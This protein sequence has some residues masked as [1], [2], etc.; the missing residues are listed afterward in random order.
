MEEADSGQPPEPGKRKAAATATLNISK[1]SGTRMKRVSS[2]LR[3]KHESLTAEDKRV[4]E[5]NAELVEQFYKRK[6]KRAVWLS[7][8]TELEDSAEELEEKCKQMAQA[9]HDAE[10]LVVYTGAGIST[11]ASIPDYRGPNGI[12]TL[13]QK[14]QDIGHHDL[15]AAE[16]TLTHMALSAL[17]HQGIVKH[18]VSQNCDGLH[19]RSGLPKSAM[20]EVHGNMYIEV[21]KNCVPARE[22]VRTF[23]VTERTSTFKHTTGRRCYRCG[24]PVIDTIVHFGERGKL[25]WPLNWQGACQAANACDTILCLGSSLKVLK[26]YPWLWQMDRPP[27]KRPSLY[28]VNLQWTPKDKD[29]TLKI[30]GKC[31][32]VMA[33]VMKAMGYELPYYCRANDPI[34]Y[35]ATPLHEAEV[36]ISTRPQLVPPS[37][38]DEEPDVENVTDDKSKECTGTSQASEGDVRWKDSDGNIV[39]ENKRRKVED[40]EEKFSENKDLLI[41]S[42]SESPED[43]KTE[44]KT[45]IKNE[46]DC[47][48]SE[49]KDDVS[50]VNGIC[51]ALDL[52]NYNFCKREDATDGSALNMKSEEPIKTEQQLNDVEFENHGN[53]GD[54]WTCGFG[55]LYKALMS[56]SIDL[57][58]P[59]STTFRESMLAEEVK[60]EASENEV[61]AMSLEESLEDDDVKSEASDRGAAIE[62]FEDS[63]EDDEGKS[64]PLEEAMADSSMGLGGSYVDSV[65]DDAK[66]EFSESDEE[67]QTSEGD[68]VW[69][70]DEASG[71][72]VSPRLDPV[73]TS[74]SSSDSDVS[75]K[76]DDDYE[77]AENINTNVSSDSSTTNYFKLAYAS[78]NIQMAQQGRALLQQNEF[79][80]TG[81]CI[82]S[83]GSSKNK[84][85]YVGQ[86][87]SDAER[88][89]SVETLSEGQQPLDLSL[90]VNC[91]S[92]D[93]NPKNLDRINCNDLSDVRSTI[94]QEMCAVDKEKISSLP[95]CHRSLSNPVPS[96]N[97]AGIKGDSLYGGVPVGTC[98]GGTKLVDFYNSFVSERLR[99]VCTNLTKQ[100]SLQVLENKSLGRNGFQDMDNSLLVRTHIVDGII[101]TAYAE[102]ADDKDSDPSAKSGVPLTKVKFPRSEFFQRNEL[103]ES[104][105]L[106][107]LWYQSFCNTNVGKNSNSL[108]S[109]VKNGKVVRQKKENGLD[110][111][112]S[113]SDLNPS[114][115][116][117]S[118][119]ILKDICAEAMNDSVARQKGSTKRKLKGCDNEDVKYIWFWGFNSNTE[120]SN[121]T[122]EKKCITLSD[123]SSNSNS[124]NMRASEGSDGADSPPVARV[125]RSRTRA[126]SDSK[127]IVE[128]EVFRCHCS[129]T[130]PELCKVARE[131]P[132]REKCEDVEKARELFRRRRLYNYR[133]YEPVF[134][135]EL[136]SF[137][138]ERSKA[139]RKS[140]F[141]LMQEQDED[142]EE[143]EEEEQDTEPKEEEQKMSDVEEVKEKDEK[144][145]KKFAPGWYGKGLR[146]GMKKKTRI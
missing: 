122:P 61:N 133:K 127:V 73:K 130:N 62:S 109:K 55:Q 69:L 21:C 108:P 3:K 11:A 102:S 103:S 96:D 77:G 75:E 34:F 26:K 59:Y 67:P 32:V 124:E 104:E 25:R 78:T 74:D 107:D 146:K 111:N 12:W 20:S 80:G 7:R 81:L 125:T 131:R 101:Q 79:Y 13:L 19:L 30:N 43:I 17:Y 85:N 63:L 95:S 129:G 46:L 140:K 6:E 64:Q 83:L 89:S 70:S 56:K 92:F 93:A 100:E 48:K 91:K 42:E 142:G 16:P 141:E 128:P 76:S 113:R 44:V 39:E 1:K 60:S 36:N 120:N 123:N 68:D 51:T 29:A 8:K 82:R 15:S 24:E 47:V 66:S 90:P 137:T 27:K 116:K 98:S 23:D 136:E 110:F 144:E 57:N 105:E 31:D 40:D 9:I 10:F 28:I 2:I 71:N 52:T 132:P 117:S 38:D 97:P 139:K 41:K 33:L 118:S 58:E 94:T 138:F 121:N 114:S 84:M 119:F 54:A 106:K 37:E 22:Y 145:E 134:E 87:R 99:D 135:K 50:H 14:G 115:E 143:D 4:L 126:S 35:L 53:N 72:I 45:E 18:V 88:K 49:S 112:V 5:E 86:S 65:E